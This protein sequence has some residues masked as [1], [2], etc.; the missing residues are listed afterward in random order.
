M[1]GN[2]SLITSNK[3]GVF[4]KKQLLLL[5]LV[6]TIL[7]SGL[8]GMEKQDQDFLSQ[9][10]V[11][12][13][14]MILADP[15]TTPKSFALIKGSCKALN[16]ATEQ[17]FAKEKVLGHWFYENKTTPLHTIA[18]Q[19]DGNLK[20]LTSGD[21]R[22]ICDVRRLLAFLIRKPGLNPIGYSLDV[23][24]L[25]C[26][27]TALDY[28]IRK[29]NGWLAAFLRWFGGHETYFIG[30][31]DNPQNSFEEILRHLRDSNIVVNN[32]LV[33][34]HLLN[35]GI[36]NVNPDTFSNIV[37]NYDVAS[38]NLS[39]NPITNLPA[40]IGDMTR[41]KQLFLSPDRLRELPSEIGN[42]INL[43]TLLL[44][45]PDL[46]F[47]APLLEGLPETLGQLENLRDL[48]IKHL[49]LTSLPRSITNLRKL[50]SINLEGNS[51]D[52]EAIKLIAEI[53][54]LKELNLPS[55]NLNT[56]PDSIRNLEKLETID[57]ARNSLTTEEVAKLGVLSSLTWLN[58]QDN[59]E[60]TQLPDELRNLEMLEVLVLE[61]CSNLEALPAWLPELENLKA[62]I[63]PSGQFAPDNSEIIDNLREHEI[64][65][66]I[67]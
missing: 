12:L 6:S 63:L 4:M 20:T 39:G 41:L 55:N 13:L 65:V 21:Q 47:H 32:K 43:E 10:P 59:Q 44:T 14:D 27:Q 45:G 54:S 50:L 57:L 40:S 9:L 22:V 3:M 33:C 30:G 23:N 35:K 67:S 38:L 8:T 19:A 34:I 37:E 7:F 48:R 61:G 28:A 16:E 46:S 26:N 18:F 53:R 5:T 49:R 31:Q 64:N 42:L 29:E 24:Q 62:I 15:S 66:V 11:E 51:L 25:D 52:E 1:H 56:I 58:L 2:N 17:N 60:L 36:R